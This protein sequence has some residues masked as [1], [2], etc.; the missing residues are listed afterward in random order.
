MKRI[1]EEF[2][3]GNVTPSARCFVRGTKYDEACRMLCRNEERLMALLAEAEGEIF[4]RYQDCQREMNQISECETFIQ[5][6]QLGARFM[7]EVLTDDN[8]I[9][10]EI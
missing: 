3:Y 9:F 2:W 10:K 6:F 4:Q 5:G 7:L 8:R 1:L